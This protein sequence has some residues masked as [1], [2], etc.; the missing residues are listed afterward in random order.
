MLAN[1]VLDAM[2]VHAV[3]WTPEGIFERGVCLQDGSLAWSERPAAG[4]VLAA[5]RPI[6]ASVLPSGRYE[7][8][9]GLAARA[10]MRSAAAALERGAILVVDYGFPEAEY[11]HPQ[12]SSGTLM[13]HYRHHAH[14]DPFHLPGLQDVTAHLDFSALARA[15][16]ES[17]LELLGYAGQAQFLVNCGIT[18]VLGE[19]N[20]ENALHYA[21]LASEAHKLLSPAEMGEL[22]KVIAL[23]RGA[24]Q[25]LLG[26]TRGDRSL[27]L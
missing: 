25:P 17:G 5:A 7:S 10:W 21:P 20:A 11:Y 18:D 3:A 19:A 14:G 22:Y 26:F 23:G 1:E 8:E 13:C 15:A 9:L 4:E 12:R 27:T 24:A 6:P 16:L 2:P